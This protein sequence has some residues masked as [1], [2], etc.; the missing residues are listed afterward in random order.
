MITADEFSDL[1]SIKVETV[2]NG[3]VC[4]RNIIA[5]MMY[6]PAFIVSFFSKIMTLQPGDVILTGTPGLVLIR[7]GDTLECRITGLSSLTNTV[8]KRA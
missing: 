6:Q 3:A 2:L 5:N 7:E 8:K 1:A 4:H